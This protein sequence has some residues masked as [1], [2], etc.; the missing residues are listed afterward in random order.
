MPRPTATTEELL[1]ATR[2]LVEAAKGP[3]AEAATLKTLAQ[4]LMRDMD[5]LMKRKDVPEALRKEIEDVRKA[6]KRTWADLKGEA[7]GE[8]E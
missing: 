3:I 1:K 8:S 7:D 5:M 6:L 4:S 2:N